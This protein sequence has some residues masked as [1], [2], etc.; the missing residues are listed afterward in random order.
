VTLQEMNYSDPNGGY[1]S[2][3][4]LRRGPSW[5]ID[6]YPTSGARIAM[7]TPGGN[8]ATPNMNAQFG[9]WMSR[10]PFQNF[11]DVAP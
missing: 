7:R 8:I 2:L 1:D 9:P 6:C 10:W 3:W 11:Q 5:R 4:F